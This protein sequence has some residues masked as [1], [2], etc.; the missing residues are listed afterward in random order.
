MLITHEFPLQ[1]YKNGFAKKTTDYD[2]CL[3]HRYISNKEYREYMKDQV[4]KGR[5]VYLDNSLYEL[6]KAWDSEEYAKVIKDLEP[7]FYMLPDVFD[8]PEEN[9]KSQISFYEKHLVEGYRSCVIII[10]HSNTLS[11]LMESINKLKEGIKSYDMI[12]IPF[13]DYSFENK[14]KDKEYFT[15]EDI[16]YA[17][18]RMAYNRK[19][20]LEKYHKEL[21]NDRIHLLGCKSI[22]E[23]DLWSNS[24]NKNNIVSL[25]TSHPVAM[26]LENKYLTYNKGTFR[27]NG[28]LYP[29][30]CYKS[31]YLIDKHFEDSFEDSFENTIEKALKKNIE[32]FQTQVRNWS[33]SK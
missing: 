12:A 18:L 32:Y 6:G 9:I 27:D 7:R 16:S 10:P 33:L 24:F 2:Y 28:K 17:P 26:T 23:F 11:G 31:N 15:E 3:A 14:N 19:L 20:F 1:F 25:D 29:N 21:K 30:H 13:A 4:I 22:A 5:V 8:N